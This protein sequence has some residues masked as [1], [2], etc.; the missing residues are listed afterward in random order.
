MAARI[1]SGWDLT[2]RHR[3]TEA[4]RGRVSRERIFERCAVVTR[5]LLYSGHYLLGPMQRWIFFESVNI[6][7]V[8]GVA[9]KGGSGWQSMICGCEGEIGCSRKLIGKGVNFSG[10]SR[11]FSST[12]S[13]LLAGQN[14]RGRGTWNEAAIFIPKYTNI[15]M[16][17]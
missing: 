10:R 14:D 3:G 2:Q 7:G 15:V 17:Q 1:R 9:R 6:V 8:V 5:R 11:R 16:G 4:Q 13:M 12:T